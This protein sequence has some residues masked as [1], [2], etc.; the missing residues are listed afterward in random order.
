M[1]YS[2]GK[3]LWKYQ[4]D[5]IHDPAFRLYLFQEEKDV[6]E[7]M[8]GVTHLRINGQ[9]VDTVKIESIVYIYTQENDTII[10]LDQLAR[11][12]QNS[13]NNQFNPEIPFTA[14]AEVPNVKRLPIKF[15]FKVIPDKR[16]PKNIAKAVQDNEKPINNYFLVYNSENGQKDVSHTCGGNSGVLQANTYE[17]V[18]VHEMLH[19][20]GWKL[21]DCGD[22]SADGNSIMD[23]TPN[24]DAVITQ[25][26]IDRLGTIKSGTT[27]CMRIRNYIYDNPNGFPG[28]PI[29]NKFTNK[30]VY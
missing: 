27:Q 9:W 10:E 30:T 22:H 16:L 29:I 17:S 18:W 6:E 12:M 20:L 14:K 13:L 5:W 1:D 25:P 7:S 4:W 11:K 15:S 3:E 24:E 23:A 26:D 2:R 8:G 19:V 28:D 21:K